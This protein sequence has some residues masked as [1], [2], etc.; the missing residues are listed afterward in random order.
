[1]NYI[2][3]F[4]IMVLC[5]SILIGYNQGFIKSLFNIANIVIS[6]LIGLLFYGAIA[7]SIVREEQVMP[8][9][10]HFSESSEMLDGIENERI[11]IYEK[12]YE[13]IST[14]VD[15]VKLPHPLDSLLMKNIKKHS[16]DST[17]ETTLGDYLGKTIGHMTINY[18]SFIIGFFVSFFILFI[19]INVVDYVVGFSVLR[20]MDS[21]AGGIGGLIQGL[22][23]VN[24]IFL[25]VPLILAFLPFD[26]LLQFVDSS[27]FSRVYYYSNILTKLISGVI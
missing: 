4:V 19:V 12:S 14:L 15:N 2:D 1:M 8:T 24:I 27:S 16:F 22:I 21:V 25:I 20:S 26:E 18:I 7:N 23:L 11:S 10:V 9:I 17:G 6:I 5:I 13:E 3:I